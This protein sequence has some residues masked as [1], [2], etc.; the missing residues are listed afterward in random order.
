LWPKKEEKIT[1]SLKTL[2]T[3]EE[4]LFLL[5]FVR[6]YYGNTYKTQFFGEKRNKKYSQNATLTNPLRTKALLFD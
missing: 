1:I 3:L 2:C 6:K 5:L 4:I